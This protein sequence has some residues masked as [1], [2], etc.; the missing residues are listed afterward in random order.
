VTGLL[1]LVLCFFY[2]KDGPKFVPW[3]GGLGRPR[4]APHVAPSCS[5]RGCTLSGFIKAQAA[6]GLVDAVLIG[7]GLAVLG[8][9]L[10]LPLSVLVFF[11]AFI[12]I[13]GAVVSGALAALVAW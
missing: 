3:V 12:P 8:V 9:P 10:A 13:I 1:A 6:V 11:G 2:L 4:A 5:A 7:I